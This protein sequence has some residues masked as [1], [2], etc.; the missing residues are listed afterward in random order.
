MEVLH[1][2]D[3]IEIHGVIRDKDQIAA[4][5]YIVSN[6]ETGDEAI[7]I[8]AWALLDAAETLQAKLECAA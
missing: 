1:G 4:Y 5:D 2:R 8:V 3:Q 6:I 7:D